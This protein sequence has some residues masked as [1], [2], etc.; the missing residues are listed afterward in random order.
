MPISDRCDTRYLVR[1]FSTVKSRRGAF[2]TVW[3][4]TA[5]GYVINPTFL[6]FVPCDIGFQDG[7]SEYVVA[8][9]FSADRKIVSTF[10]VR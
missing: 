10:S 9:R 4:N 3:P 2:E 8:E 5:T 7:L 6:E 1:E